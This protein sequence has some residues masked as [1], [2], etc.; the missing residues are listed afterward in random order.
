MGHARNNGPFAKRITMGDWY[1]DVGSATVAY[2]IHQV[3]T[4]D[5]RMK[6]HQGFDTPWGPLISLS[7]FFW[8]WRTRQLN[9]APLFVEVRDLASRLR[10]LVELG[11]MAL[12]QRYFRR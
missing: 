9:H 4:I 10:T 1:A 6:N 11:D 2:H 7:G 3:K 8:A 5:G 12:S